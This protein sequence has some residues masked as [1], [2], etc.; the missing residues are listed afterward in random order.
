MT[1]TAP[2]NPY[3]GV[4][5]LEEIARMTTTTAPTNPYPN[6]APPFRAEP[7]IAD[8]FR[9]IRNILDVYPAEDWTPEDARDVLATLSL[10]V[11]RRQAKTAADEIDG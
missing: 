10:I 5:P 1:T 4:T 8:T 6:V 7:P 9:R 2:T 3:P 11:C